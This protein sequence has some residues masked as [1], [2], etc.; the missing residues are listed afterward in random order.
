MRTEVRR[1]EDFE[2]K[3]LNNLLEHDSTF[4][5]WI[6][7]R[8]K[9]ASGSFVCDGNVSGK[10]YEML[11]EYILPLI[12]EKHIINYEKEKQ[13]VLDRINNTPQPKDQ[14]F[15][16]GAR[17]TIVNDTHC[18]SRIRKSNQATVEY[19]YAHATGERVRADDYSLNIDGEGSCC[20]Y[21]ENLLVLIELPKS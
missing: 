7:T 1:L 2:I 4:H 10:L 20:W 21:N 12:D 11:D 9:G 3:L 17:V 18:S 5:C 19:T 8:L 13:K 6:G 14:K 15:P 16:I